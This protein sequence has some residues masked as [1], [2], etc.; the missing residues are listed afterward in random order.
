MIEHVLHW[1]GVVV[2]LSPLGLL[3]LLGGVPLFGWQLSES[4]IARWTASIVSLGLLASTLILVLMLSTG[5]RHVPVE[6]GDWVSLPEQHFHFHLK[7]VFDRLSVP[8]VILTF[9]LVGTIGAFANQYLHRESGYRRFFLFYAV[10]L[11][12]MVGALLAGTIETLFFGWE[13]VGLSSALLVAYFHDRPSPVVNGFRVWTVYRFADAAFLIAAL[14]LHHLSGQG[15]FTGLMGSDPW[16]NGQTLLTQS[17]AT[18]IGLLLLVA[19][20]GKSG[21]IPFS[22]WLPRAMEGP[23]PSSAVFYGAL[24]VNLGAY[25]LL[26]ISPLIEAS[27]LLRGA[28]IVIGV[29]SALFAAASARVQSDVKSTLAFA[30]LT[31][32]GLITV[33]IGVGLYYVAIIH[34]VGHACFRT[35]QLLRAPSILHDYHV[36]ENALGKHLHELESSPQRKSHWTP[37]YHFAYRRGYFDAFLDKLIVS[38]FLATFR[39]FARV[40]ERISRAIHGERTVG[41]STAD[42]SINELLATPS[43]DSEGVA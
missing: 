10:F 17:Q 12:G 6:L 4:A 31:Q 25:L 39:W 11:V 3:T 1:L 20:A 23:T 34:M 14:A 40:E 26:R 24:S 2:L 41:R 19:A 42:D 36:L 13:M 9:V 8:F 30:S 29:S 28:V 32:I 18:F 15:D 43:T 5:T 33:E 7:F 22:G 35:L 27:L 21:L 16:P 38:P 37:L